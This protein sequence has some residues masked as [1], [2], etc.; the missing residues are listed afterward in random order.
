[1]L[2]GL[3]QMKITELV[4][5]AA[6]VTIGWKLTSSSKINNEIKNNSKNCASYTPS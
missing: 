6:N 4:N 5:T 2:N 1:M 3:L